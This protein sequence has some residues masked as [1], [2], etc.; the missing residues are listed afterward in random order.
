LAL[1]I[2]LSA[3]SV[4]FGT[5]FGFLGGGNFRLHALAVG[6][7]A[8]LSFIFLG[9]AG[10]TCFVIGSALLFSYTLVFLAAHRDVSSVFGGLHGFTRGAA[11][12]L[13]LLAKLIILGAVERIFGFG[14]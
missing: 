4:R 10:A 5:G 14:P 7:G 9:C 6:I 8:A 13:V 12:G 11:H 3:G 1:G 2:G